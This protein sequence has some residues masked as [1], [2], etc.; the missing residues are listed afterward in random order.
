[1][2]KSLFTEAQ[3]IGI[4]KRRLSQL[5]PSVKGTQTPTEESHEGADQAVRADG[6]ER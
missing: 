2:R 4:L 5:N 6:F 3:V 1:M